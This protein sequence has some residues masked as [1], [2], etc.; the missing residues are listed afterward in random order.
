[1]KSPENDKW[2]DEALTDVIGSEETRT[3]FEQWK[4]LHP[5]AVEMLTSRAGRGPSA[6]AGQLSIRRIIMKSPITRLA[7]AAVM[8][9]AVLIGIDQL[10]GSGV[11][12]AEVARRVDQALTYTCRVHLRDL[13]HEKEPM[14][15]EAVVYGSTEYG[16]KQDVGMNGKFLKH[17]YFLPAENMQID[18]MPAE[19]KYRRKPLTDEDIEQHGGGD[20]RETLKK[21]MAYE[22]KKLGRDRIDGMDVEG[23]EVYDP[24]LCTASF[25][26]D[27]LTAQLWVDV[28]TSLPVLLK[29]EI[30]GTKREKAILT[31]E[32]FQWNVK[33]D[34]SVFE[35]NIPEDYTMTE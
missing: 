16:Q 33:L 19:K 35:P 21:C 2:L 12:W 30:K 20:I 24:N 6:T 27:S 17:T 25:T 11:A 32:K 4:K 13:T 14:N 7:A 8:I 23:I 31:A 18:V 3:D 1:M 9:A 15:I 34:P 26:V 10:G 5:Q 29:A 28:E 22:H